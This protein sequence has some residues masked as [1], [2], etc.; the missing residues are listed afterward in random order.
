MIRLF[1]RGIRYR[2]WKL[3]RIRASPHE[4]ALGL[5]IGIF[6]GALPIMGIQSLVAIPM[7]FVW[8]AS[9]AASLVGVW[10]T[11][12]LTFIPIYYSEYLIGGLLFADKILTYQEFYERFSQIS[13]LDGVLALG[14]D[15]FG[16]MTYGSLVLGG[17]LGLICY[18]TMV[19][20]LEERRRRKE[21]RKSKIKPAEK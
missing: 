2:Y 10:W 17:S 5:G 12:P 20:A 15:I 1:P 11:N 7:A 16:P 8:R 4:V 9:I 13:D 21:I 19:R 6:C 18:L 14:G 3:I